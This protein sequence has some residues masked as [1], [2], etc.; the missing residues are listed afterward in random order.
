[1]VSVVSAAE[2][3]GSIGDVI[4][5]FDAVAGILSEDGATRS[6]VETVVGNVGKVG[7]N[8]GETGDAGTTSKIGLEIGDTGD[9][10][11][12]RTEFGAA[13]EGVEAVGDEAD[14][15]DING[16]M[17]GGLVGTA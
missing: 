5:L 7:T 15:I 16:L 11:G 1:M 10:I 6:G 13:T 2:A 3:G 12:E 17:V 14:G 8:N 4:A 9:A